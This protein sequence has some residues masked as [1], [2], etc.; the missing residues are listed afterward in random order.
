MK[1]ET[2]AE[3]YSSAGTV[4]DSEL[5]LIIISSASLLANIL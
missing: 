3:L 1:I 5:Q 2:K 4:A